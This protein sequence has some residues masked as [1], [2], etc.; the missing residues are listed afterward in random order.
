M[1]ICLTVYTY[2][3]WESKKKGLPL[4]SLFH[5]KAYFTKAPQTAVQKYLL[6]QWILRVSLIA[7]HYVMQ[8]LPWGKRLKSSSSR[9]EQQRTWA[10]ISGFSIQA[11]KKIMA[12]S[13]RDINATSTSLP[14]TGQGGFL[15]YTQTKPRFKRQLTSTSTPKCGSRHFQM[16]ALGYTSCQVTLT[17]WGPRKHKCLSIL[18]TKEGGER[19]STGLCDG[20]KPQAK[21]K[22]L[23]TGEGTLKRITRV[24]FGPTFQISSCSRLKVESIFV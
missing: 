9:T 22:T 23:C 15:L 24:T 7:S 1:G 10:E 8:D 11:Q 18:V 19:H 14:E 12:R 20:S 5:A 13:R 3:T 6:P 16:T 17:N 2:L 4:L 21:L